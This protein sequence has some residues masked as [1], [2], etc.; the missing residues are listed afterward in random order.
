MSLCREARNGILTDRC[1]AKWTGCHVPTGVTDVRLVPG[2]EGARR[3]KGRPQHLSATFSTSP[4]RGVHT[5]TVGSL[6]GKAAEAI[7]KYI[8]YMKKVEGEVETRFHL[9]HP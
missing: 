8:T 3:G 9:G 1:I 4:E 2:P 7:L 6:K 5:A